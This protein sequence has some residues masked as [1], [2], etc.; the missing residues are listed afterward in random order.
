M[1]ILP[2]VRAQVVKAMSAPAPTRSLGGPRAIALTA[3]ASALLVAILALA[4]GL[5]RDGEESAGGPP[6]DGIPIAADQS[7]QN[8]DS[9][10]TLDDY[11]FK[12]EWEK[13]A[14]VVGP[15]TVLGLAAMERMPAWRFAPAR[16]HAQHL[17]RDEAEQLLSNGRDRYAAI[18]LNVLVEPHKTVTVTVARSAR[19]QVS[20]LTELPK[21]G[22]YLPADGAASVRYEGC[23][24][25]VDDTRRDEQL[26]TGYPLAII[27]AGARCVPLEIT[28]EG[29]R[30]TTKVVSFGSGRCPSP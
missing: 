1:T 16:E 4:A 20:L 3:A 24:P 25:R 29:E 15:I 26:G 28:P 17:E 10:Y 18:G 27:V 19:K 6:V 21:F 5:V 30:P 8:C 9:G 2:E 23:A 12:G 7:K 13:Q 14:I 22:G 11:H